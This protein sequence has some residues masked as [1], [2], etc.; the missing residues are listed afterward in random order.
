MLV[1]MLVMYGTGTWW[2]GLPEA[3]KLHNMFA[4]NDK[5][6]TIIIA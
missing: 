6:W 5:D 3:T 4:K 2:C 1:Q